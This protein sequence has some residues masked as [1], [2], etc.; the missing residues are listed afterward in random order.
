[1]N[2]LQEIIGAIGPLDRPAMEAA[3]ARQNSLTKPPGSL[4]RLE[5]ISIRV[6]GITGKARPCCDR[7]AV[8][9]MAG[10]HGIAAEGV[11]AYPQEVTGQMVRN[12]L[13][14]GAAINVLARHAGAKVIVVDV[15]VAADLSDLAACA[16]PSIRFVT[17]KVRPGTANFARQPAMTPEE[18]MAAIEVGVRV[19]EEELAGGLDI[20]AVGEMGIG[21]TTPGSALTAIFTGKPAAEVTGYGTGV[22]P[23]G[24]KRK[25]AVIEQAIA[26]HRPDPADP[27]GALAKVGGLEIAAMA[28]AMMAAAAHRVPV[29]A[30]GFISSAAALTAC[31]LCPAARHYLFIGHK[32]QE[33]GHRAIIEA[34]DMQ[35]VLDMGLR[36]G[37]GTGA[38]LALSLV[39]AAVKILDEMA[40]FADAGVSGGGDS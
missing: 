21:N 39:Q 10:D 29:L 14:G 6:A 31:R 26:L 1:M 8:I 17:A 2:K 5:E 40:T 30:D 22:S 13:G 33:A 11:S 38:V 16:G 23:E 9:T 20:V 24:L 28:G 35:P 36:L 7:A 37:E 4:G 18:T 34:L 32:S 25:A 3:Q 12:F 19:L 27:L 15:G